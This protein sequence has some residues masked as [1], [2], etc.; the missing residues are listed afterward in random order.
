MKLILSKGEIEECIKVKLP[1][2][3]KVNWIINGGE[4]EIEVEIDMDSIV[5]KVKPL[6]VINNIEKDTKVPGNVMG[7]RRPSLPI[8]G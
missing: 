1:N 5:K 3:S 2:I 7:S 6:P 4:V 8:I